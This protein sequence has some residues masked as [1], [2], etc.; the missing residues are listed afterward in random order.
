MPA[1]ANKEVRARSSAMVKIKWDCRS[2]ACVYMC[3]VCATPH[4][5]RVF[6]VPPHLSFSA[7]AD[8][9]SAGIGRAESLPISTLNYSK[10]DLQAL[11]GNECKNE[12]VVEGVAAATPRRLDMDHRA[13]KLRTARHKT[14]VPADGS[15]PGRVTHDLH[16]C[17]H[18]RGEFSVILYL[19]ISI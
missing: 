10:Y 4:T 16:L 7:F 2:C 6:R 5:S 12:L 11:T 15:A 9:H 14:C 13:R 19:R 18:P 8:W 17:G 3:G 1:H